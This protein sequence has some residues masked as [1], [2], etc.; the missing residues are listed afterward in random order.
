MR[1][2]YTEI[3]TEDHLRRHGVEIVRK[4]VFRSTDISFATCLKARAASSAKHLEN[5]EHRQIY[6]GTSGTIIDLRPFDDD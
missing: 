3:G 5:V 4:F 2:S 1:V 6:K